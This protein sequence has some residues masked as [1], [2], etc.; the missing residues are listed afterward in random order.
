MLPVAP[1]MRI[2][3]TTA[4][5]LALVESR[6]K[7]RSY[8]KVQQSFCRSRLIPN[9]SPKARRSHRAALE[10]IHLEPEVVAARG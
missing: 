1:V 3:F 10:G 7:G 8:G 4:I 2:L 9:C 5:L 6:T